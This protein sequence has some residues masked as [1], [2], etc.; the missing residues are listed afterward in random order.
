MWNLSTA[1]QKSPATKE[2]CKINVA[3]E[4]LHH[5]KTKNHDIVAKLLSISKQARL[6]SQQYTVVFL[7]TTCVETTQEVGLAETSQGTA[8]Y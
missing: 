7:T 6:G 2:I 4:K 8:V 5:E 1:L 3:D